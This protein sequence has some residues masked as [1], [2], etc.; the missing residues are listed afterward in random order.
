MAF[1]RPLGHLRVGGRH[2]SPRQRKSACRLLLEPLEQRQV[3]SSA[4]GNGPVLTAITSTPGSR[5]L[6]LTFDGPVLSSTA[7]DLSNYRITAPNGG[8]PQ[9]VTSS[10][11]PVRVVAAQYGDISTTSSQVTLT[12]ARPLQQGIFYRIFVNGELPITNGNPA[13]NPLTGG[14]GAGNPSNGVTF[15]GD[16]DDTACGNFYGLFAVGRRLAFTDFSGD[17]VVLAA[18][19][20]SGL[21]VWR[22]LNGDIDQVTV[23]PGATALS[24][25]VV[26]GRGSSGTVPIGSV[27]IPV[28]SPL[29][30]NGAAN[31]LPASFV[32]VPS[33]GL[34][35]PAP[36]PTATSPTPVVATSANL[37]YTLNITP[38]S[39]PGIALLPGIQSGVYAQTA[40][41]AAYPTGLWHVLGGRTNGRHNFWPS[42]VPSSLATRA[43]TLVAAIRRGWVT[44]MRPRSRPRPMASAILGS[45]VVLPLPVAPATITTGCC[46]MARVRSSTRAEIGSSGGKR[47][48]TTA[49]QRPGGG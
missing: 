13:S 15:D 20:G 28:P 2:H 10:G 1:W 43:A 36:Q 38:V 32:V 24:G 3:F 39:S 47:S 5:S 11:P 14:G 9:V 45:W 23:L 18:T 16:N 26:V 8:N 4:D 31:Q 44:P 41:S 6:V 21:N 17:R 12:L 7:T 37:P 35:A 22:E 42:G 40:A 27:T 48:V 46:S 33:G 29:V 49:A 34:A 25:S 30:L 19:G